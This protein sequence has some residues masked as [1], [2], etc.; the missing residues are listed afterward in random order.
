MIDTK[1]WA[2]SK[3]LLTLIEDR[4]KEVKSAYSDFY[5]SNIGKIDR[6]GNKV[7]LEEYILSESNSPIEKDFTIQLEKDF[8]ILKKEDLYIP[9]KKEYTPIIPSDLERQEDIFK[10][11]TKYKPHSKSSLIEKVLVDYSSKLK[12]KKITKTRLKDMPIADAAKLLEEN[13]ISFLDNALMFYKIKEMVSY[14]MSYSA[15]R[16]KDLARLSKHHDDYMALLSRNFPNHKLLAELSILADKIDDE[17]EANLPKYEEIQKIEDDLYC[18]IRKTE[19]IIEKTMPTDKHILENFFKREVDYY[20][21]NKAI[22]S[23]KESDVDRKLSFVFFS[24]CPTLSHLS[25]LMD[26]IKYATTAQKDVSFEQNDVIKLA[27]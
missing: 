14:N 26:N 7:S 4:A 13:G 2:S 17:I 10:E 5:K 25:S 3:K 6:E 24:P 8:Y 11:Y 21:L 22:L 23:G 27:I 16:D 12:E 9:F 18:S 1:I 19:T 15:S 20:K